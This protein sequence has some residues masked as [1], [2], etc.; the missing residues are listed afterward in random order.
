M[1]VEEIALS[2]Q[3]SESTIFSHITQLIRAEK[4][5]LPE[6][7]SAKRIKE[8]QDVVQQVNGSSLSQI[9]AQVGNQISWDEL[10]IY[11]ASTII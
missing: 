8:I 6:V 1:K 11:Q 2:R 4:V 10:R 9:K 3:L 5:T 7:M